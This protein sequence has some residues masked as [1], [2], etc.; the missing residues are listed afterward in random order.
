MPTRVEIFSTGENNNK[1]VVVETVTE[2][3]YTDD[4]TERAGNFAYKESSSQTHIREYPTIEEL[5][6]DNRLNRFWNGTTLIVAGS[7][8]GVA[9]AFKAGEQLIQ[10]MSGNYHGN[11]LVDVGVDLGAL[12][13]SAYVIYQGIKNSR[14]A[15]RVSARLNDLTRQGLNAVLPTRN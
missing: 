9:L 4:I 8:L 2:S 11:A 1:R 3:E 12:A 15:N 6:R 10:S 5:D 7:G 13:G 14:H